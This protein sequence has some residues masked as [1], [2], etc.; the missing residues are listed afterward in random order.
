MSITLDLP[1]ETESKLSV[2]AAIKGLELNE[3]LSEQ[4]KNIAET[5]A[6]GG[7][8]PG[9]SI[10]KMAKEFWAQIPEEE[11]DKIPTDLSI[12]YKHYLYGYPKVEPPSK[13]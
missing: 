2:M 13:L 7:L 8:T 9:E 1:P 4:L 10:T 6:S 3:F 12:N 11:M 5:P